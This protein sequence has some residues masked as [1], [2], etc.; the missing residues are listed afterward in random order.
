MS[1]DSC[2]CFYVNPK[3]RHDTKNSIILYTELLGLQTSNS[4]MSNDKLDL[5]I[6]NN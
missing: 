5:A 6:C 1:D 2:I 3:T 4:A